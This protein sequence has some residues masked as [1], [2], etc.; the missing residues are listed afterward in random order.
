MTYVTIADAQTQLAALVDAAL[1][2]EQVVIK[3]AS[4]ETIELVPQTQ[5][6]RVF[7]SL[8]GKIKMA[9]DFDEPLEDFA[10]YM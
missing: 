6:T 9:D 2:G 10:D 1:R 3:K 7:G 8:K 4:G 5:R